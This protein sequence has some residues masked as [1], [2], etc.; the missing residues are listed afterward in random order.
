V[1]SLITSKS[2]IYQTAL[3][4]LPPEVIEV[5]MPIMPPQIQYVSSGSG[6]LNIEDD[7]DKKLLKMLF[8]S[9]LG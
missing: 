7:A 1:V 9:A 8:Y 3:Q 6:S 2:K 4:E 5:P